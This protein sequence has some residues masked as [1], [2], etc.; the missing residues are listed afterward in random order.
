MAFKCLLSSF[1][2]H[3][4]CLMEGD[5]DL[6]HTAKEEVR[7]E[8]IWRHTGFIF[9]NVPKR[10]W[11]R[12]WITS[13]SSDPSHGGWRGG[14][15]QTTVNGGE[16]G[17]WS[18]H[19]TISP[20]RLVKSGLEATL[21]DTW[22]GSAVQQTSLEDFASCTVNSRSLSLPAPAHLIGKIDWRHK[23]WPY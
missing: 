21:K 7:A 8:S 10:L 1:C 15:R 5:T 22:G 19:R 4:F 23:K 9:M 13:R 6:N 11:R 20:L 17:N 12:L 3:E 14:G 16:K 18:W 2:V